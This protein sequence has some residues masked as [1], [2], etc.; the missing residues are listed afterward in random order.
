M[1]QQ[2]QLPP[3]PTG[4]GVG[5][6]GLQELQPS[7][8]R[9]VISPPRGPRQGSSSCSVSQQQTHHPAGGCL[10]STDRRDHPHPGLAWK[11]EEATSPGHERNGSR[12]QQGAAG[13]LGP[14]RPGNASG[15]ALIPSSVSALSCLQRNQGWDGPHSKPPLPHFPCSYL[16]PRP[17]PPII[18]LILLFGDPLMYHPYLSQ[19]HS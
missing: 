8:E 15:P 10:A 6:R 17:C 18:L 11:A 2:S 5:A 1:E 14:H 9:W 3:T 16:A 12:R 4:P 7:L 19:H 13:G